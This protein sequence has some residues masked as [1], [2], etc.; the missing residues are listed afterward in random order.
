MLAAV[1]LAGGCQK[2][3]REA[4]C[5]PGEVVLLIETI[6]ETIHERYDVAGCGISAYDVIR[7]RHNVSTAAGGKAIRCIDDVCGEGDYWWPMRINGTLAMAGVDELTVKK[8]DEISFR[9]GKG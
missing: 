6:G 8:G 4:D 2:A 7:L 1:L 5:R 3:G 9:L